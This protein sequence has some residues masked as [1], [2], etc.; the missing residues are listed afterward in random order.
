MV[1]MCDRAQNPTVPILRVAPCLRLLK[2]KVVYGNI[3]FLNVAQVS[4]GDGRKLDVDGRLGSQRVAELKPQS[5]Y[6]FL[7][8]NKADGSEGLQH[9]ADAMTAPNLLPRKPQLVEKSSSESTATLQLPSVHAHTPVRSATHTHNEN[10]HLQY[11]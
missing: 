4:Y 11:S 9:R 10:T 6:T 7:L 2:L 8:S 3:C 5:L 1:S